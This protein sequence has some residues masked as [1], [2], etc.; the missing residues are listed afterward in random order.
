MLI[1]LNNCYETYKDKKDW[2]SRHYCQT[3]I[4]SP[5]AVTNVKGDNPLP[6]YKQYAVLIYTCIQ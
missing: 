3:L 6:T 4:P 1:I 5:S 2:S